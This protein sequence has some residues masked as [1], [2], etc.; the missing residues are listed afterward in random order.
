[1]YVSGFGRRLTAV[2]GPLTSHLQ[3]QAML[4]VP[5][6]ASAMTRVGCGGSVSGLWTPGGRTRCAALAPTSSETVD[7]GPPSTVGHIQTHM[8]IFSLLTTFCSTVRRKAGIAGI[9][10]LPVPPLSSA[11]SCCVVAPWLRAGWGEKCLPGTNVNTVN[12]CL[13][14]VF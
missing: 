4:R 6:P 3:G 1:M 10:G 7:T 9:I 5:L 2:R 12:L 13:S 14:P 11:H 8:F